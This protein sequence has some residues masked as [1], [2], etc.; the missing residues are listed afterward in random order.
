L[1]PGE[2]LPSSV[3]PRGE[4][5]LSSLISLFFFPL[6]S[7]STPGGPFP[8]VARARRHGPGASSSALLPGALNPIP[9]RA[10]LARV[11]FKFSFNTLLNSV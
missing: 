1:D 9:V 4:L 2:R 7:H 11:T 6:P 5:P 10:T 8:G 3:E